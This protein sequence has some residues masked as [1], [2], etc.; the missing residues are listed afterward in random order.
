MKGFVGDWLRGVIKPAATDAPEYLQSFEDPLDLASWILRNELQMLLREEG[1]T[2]P[3][4]PQNHTGPAIIA[5]GETAKREA[6]PCLT[7]DAAD[8][9]QWRLIPVVMCHEWSNRK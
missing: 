7:R 4:R 8:R 9:Y 5:A 1:E 2:M 3:P 6:Q